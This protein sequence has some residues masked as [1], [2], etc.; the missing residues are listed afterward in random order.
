V[1]DPRAT[2]RRILVLLGVAAASATLAAGLLAWRLRQGAIDLAFVVPTVERA[3][4]RPGAFTVQIGTAELA[5]DVRDRRVTLRARDIHV[6][7][8]RGAPVASVPAVAL[9]PSLRALL[10]GTV[11]LGA[12]QL[13]GPRLRLVR[14]PAGG[15]DLGLG[16]AAGSGTQELL[17]RLVPSRRP[18]AWLRSVDIRDGEVIV[19]DPASG[20]SWRAVGVDMRVEPRDGG[21]GGALRGDVDIGDGVVPV[22]GDV[23]YRPDGSV[24][25]V[26]FGAV[27][28]ASA[29]ALL[30]EEHWRAL[31][32]GAVLPV[33]G[34]VRLELDGRFAP[35]TVRVTAEGSAGAVAIAGLFPGALPV[36]GLRIAATL[37]VGAD[38]LAVESL[39]VDL[40]DAHVEA[41]GTLADLHGAR[42]I[43][44]ETRISHLPADDLA[45]YWPAA[46][47]PPTREW[48]TKRVSAGIVRDGAVRLAGRM[49]NAGL[50]DTEVSGSVTFE[51]LAVRFLDTMPSARGVAGTGTFTGD[52]WRL[53]VARGVVGEL[54]V[55]HGTVDLDLAARRS[56]VRAAVSGP[57]AAALAIAQQAQ[58]E[59]DFGIAG[60]DGRLAAEVRLDLPLRTRLR[61]DDVRVAVTAKMRDVAAPHVLRG[62]SFSEGDL[63]VDVHGQALAIV[64]QGRVEGA[65]I[66]VVWKDETGRD[67]RID[68]TSRLDAAARAALGFELRPWVDGPVDVRARLRETKGAGTLEVTAD[69]SEASISLPV[70]AVAK[71][72]GA[73]GTA[74]ARVVLA[75][76]IAT[77]V[78][79]FGFSAAGASVTG[80]A[81][82]A[83][84][85]TALR[86]LDASAKIAARDARHPAGHVS[87]AVD[88]GRDA[89]HPF[90]LASDDAGALFR[91]IAPAAEAT[92]GRLRY[93]GTVDLGG[94]GLPIDGRLE[95][96]DF[97][98]LRS[99]VL[100]RVAILASLSGIADLLQ[101]RGIV[102]DRLDA[103]IASRGVTLTITEGVARGPSVN[104][105]VAGTVDRAEWTA[106]LHGTLVPSYY[107]LN[108]ATGRVP[109]LGALIAGDERQGIEAFDF[110][111][112]GPVS[113]PQVTVHL[114][115][116]APGALRDLTRRVPGVCR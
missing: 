22:R 35:Q 45:T 82:L 76:G 16:E 4:G 104:V 37:D 86:S 107:G 94:T 77:E 5:W 25:D 68:V 7:D 28:P 15:F 67:R 92:G 115:S 11:A 66:S 90:V 3:L 46:L 48:V 114:T 14:T 98:L 105:L 19:A 38:A 84:D 12:V 61:S 72:P 42:R 60:A 87:L 20:R 62:W 89:G 99:P 53:R 8:V 108:A 23:V 103:G 34:S 63:D 2:R 33:A 26:R 56:V 91:A 27:T 17:R 101:G 41:N 112:N 55:A 116:L 49:E 57:V 85:G 39:S 13:I 40:P 65:P 88:A 10:R 109:V 70:L 32:E 21:A 110:D 24:A 78:E 59:R 75:R 31:L 96:H 30:P 18:G 69:L 64:G 50:V 36:R 43:E 29:A 93:A 100:A 102:F 111:V 54:E 71:P 6:L 1:R 9:R 51:G 58:P 97:R 47:A 74:D 44:M 106:S 113:E 79:H 73:V 80:R 95:L 52:R 83:A 81:A